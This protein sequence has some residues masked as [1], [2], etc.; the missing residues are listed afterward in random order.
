MP[1]PNFG[2]LVPFVSLGLIGGGGDYLLIRAFEYGPAA[3]SAPLGYMELVGTTILGYLIFGNFPDRWTWIG[4]GII[5]ASGL[6]IGF[7]ERRRRAQARA[8]TPA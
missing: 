7:R 3:V 1:P 2:D 6:F 5:I 4:A 8:S